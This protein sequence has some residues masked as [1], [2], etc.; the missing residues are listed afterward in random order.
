MHAEDESDNQIVETEPALFEINS[1]ERA[2]WLVRKIVECR[3]YGARARDFA[4]REQRR[5]VREEQRLLWRFGRQ[6]EMWA[7]GEIAKF[8]GR[9]RSVS[10]P[11]GTL[12]YRRV[13]PRVVVDDAAAVLK[14]AREHCPEVVIK[15]ERVSTAA[16]AELMKATGVVP[17]E[18]A[19]IEP[20]TDR[21]HIR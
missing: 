19:H 20:E 13:G 1:P 3:A 21:F 8:G 9:R 11:A 16:L 15:T 6:L 5:A 14:W 17:P 10:L 18:G 2:N 7:A 4:E 12:S